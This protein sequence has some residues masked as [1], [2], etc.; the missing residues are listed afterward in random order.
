LAQQ[1]ISSLYLVEYPSANGAFGRVS[2]SSN[3]VKFN[4]YDHLLPTI[5]VPTESARAFND[6]LDL[7]MNKVVPAPGPSKF[8]AP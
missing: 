4:G 2:F 8:Y 7:L 3:C 1:F 5:S 6:A